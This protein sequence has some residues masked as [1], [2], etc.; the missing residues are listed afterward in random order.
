M[1]NPLISGSDAG[2]VNVQTQSLPTPTPSP[3]VRVP[4]SPQAS[5]SNTA[6]DGNTHSSEHTEPLPKALGS[7]N[8]QLQAWATGMRFDIDQD[9]QRVVVSIIDNETGDVLRTVPSDAVLRVAK[10]IVQLQGNGVDT[11]V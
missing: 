3:D 8:Q 7:L 9:A 4:P 10:M 6:S 11:K 1:V 5:N 2:L